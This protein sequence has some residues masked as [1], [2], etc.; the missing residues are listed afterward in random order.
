MIY[1]VKDTEHK[2]LLAVWES[3]VRVTHDFLQEEDFMF[4]KELIP[5]FFDGVLLHCI[6]NGENQIVGFIGTHAGSLEMLFVR[7]DYIGTGVGKK[8]LLHAI[9]N[10]NVTKVDVNK[11]NI[12]AAAFYEYFGFEVQS[13]SDLDGF[14]KPYPIL[15]MELK[16]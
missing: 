12:R 11:D 3:S 9:G 1:T 5:S 13:V 2:E 6:K 15:H 10:L 8:L 14:G 4:Y 7:A 16:A